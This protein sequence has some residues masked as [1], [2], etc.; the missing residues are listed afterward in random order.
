MTSVSCALDRLKAIL[1]S[2]SEEEISRVVPE[3]EGNHLMTRGLIINI[4]M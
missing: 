4:K 1:Q 2:G 3:A